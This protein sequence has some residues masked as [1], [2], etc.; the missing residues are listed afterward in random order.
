[1]QTILEGDIFGQEPDL[2]QD[3]YDIIGVPDDNLLDLDDLPSFDELWVGIMADDAPQPPKMVNVTAT[4]VEFKPTLFIKPSLMA[5]N[6]GCS[7]IQDYDEFF[8]SLNHHEF[9]TEDMEQALDGAENMDLTDDVDP[10]EE[11]LSAA[12]KPKS[13]S[14]YA[15]DQLL[16]PWELEGSLDFLCD[17]LAAKIHSVFDM[18]SY[19]TFVQNSLN[20][21]LQNNK[22]RMTSKQRE[23]FFF[24]GDCCAETMFESMKL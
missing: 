4:E 8:D 19:K 3:F 14:F 11:L 2:G 5:L 1:M 22:V 7:P 17:Q 23:T 21:W 15:T 6:R 18:A 20:V 16:I 9:T 12:L 13:L 10:I 24:L